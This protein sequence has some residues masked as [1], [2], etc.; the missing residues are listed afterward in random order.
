MQMDNKDGNTKA[1]TLRESVAF[2][3][4]LVFRGERSLTPTSELELEGRRSWT[5]K[6]R[7][8]E[9]GSVSDIQGSAFKDGG[10]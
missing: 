7:P 5:A 2:S 1:P 10:F 9:L 4:S 3:S 8:A 6:E